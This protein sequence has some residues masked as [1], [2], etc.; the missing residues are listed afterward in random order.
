[1]QEERIKMDVGT[2]RMG[3][4]IL[5]L[6]HVTFN[7]GE[8]PILKDFHYTFKRNEKI[9]LIGNNGSGKST[10]LEIITGMLPP[11]AGRIEKGET[12]T[13]GYYRQE[14]I[15]FNEDTRVIDVV[16]NIAE[17]VTLGN[18][19]TISAA[20]FLN[21]FLFPY[22]VHYQLVGRLS[23]G[24]KRRLYLVTV[25]MQNPN[26]LILDEPTNDL[27][28]FT[29]AILEEY[30]ASFKGCVIIVTHDRYFLDEIVDHLFVFEGNAVIRDFPGNYTQF[31]E[32]RKLKEKHTNRLIQAASQKK[33]KPLEKEATG[34]RLSYKEQKELE[35]LESEITM[36]EAEKSGLET[37]LSS[38]TLSPDELTL[39]SKRYSELLVEISGK[40][41]RW[42][43]LSE[44][45]P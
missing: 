25:L 22:P 8:L 35:A 29:L 30:L 15:T 5:E 28:I 11:S 43:E 17:V 37:E 24:E 19:D 31:S 2:G 18:G 27:D 21:Y 10:F 42:V 26:F 38:G 12:I 20:A 45:S 14:G 32:Y 40:S 34:K 6:R 23:G 44:K 33:E 1:V 39:K 16:R 3:K 7:W 4:K 36:L 13:F 41:D 9:G